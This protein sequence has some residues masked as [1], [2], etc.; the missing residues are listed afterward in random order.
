MYGVCLRR[1]SLTDGSLLIHGS[2]EGSPG[3]WG[4]FN[5]FNMFGSHETRLQLKVKTISATLWSVISNFHNDEDN[6]EGEEEEDIQHLL[7]S[8]S[9]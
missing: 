6:D 3:L 9:V 1:P 4:Q 7:Y 5:L 8:A 2:D